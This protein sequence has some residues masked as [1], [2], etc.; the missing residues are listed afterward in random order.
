MSQSV[1]FVLTSNT[2]VGI[3]TILAVLFFALG[4]IFW[5]LI[6]SPKRWKQKAGE[7]SLSLPQR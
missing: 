2:V 7:Y 3:F 5:L 1:P 4:L 6:F